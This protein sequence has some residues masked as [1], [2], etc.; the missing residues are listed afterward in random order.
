MGLL[1]SNS[2]PICESNCAR[3]YSTPRIARLCAPLPSGPK[4]RSISSRSRGVFIST[5]SISMRKVLQ[6]RCRPLRDS[7]GST[8]AYPALPCRAFLFRRFAANAYLSQN[9]DEPIQCIHGDVRSDSQFVF[10]KLAPVH[11]ARP[12]PERLGA[13]NVPEIRRYERDR[14]AGYSQMLRSQAVHARARLVDLHFV[15][16]DHA[17]EYAFETGVLHGGSEHSRRAIR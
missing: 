17:G 13:R 7:I 5:W 16:A 14:I 6:P 9:W 8:S 12:E 4:R 3:E 11:P 10:R 1:S 15:N 2:A